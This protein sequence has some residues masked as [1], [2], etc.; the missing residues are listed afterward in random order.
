MVERRASKLVRLSSELEAR[1]ASFFLVFFSL[2]PRGNACV[3]GK[4]NRA[5]AASCTLALNI[6][7]FKL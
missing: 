6:L 1:D 2:L 7:D 3:A 5:Q 4:K